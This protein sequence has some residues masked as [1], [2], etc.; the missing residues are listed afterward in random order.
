MFKEVRSNNHVIKQPTSHIHLWGVYLYF[1]HSISKWPP[2]LSLTLFDNQW[3]EMLD[4]SLKQNPKCATSVDKKQNWI[5]F[6]RLSVIQNQH[7]QLV[8]GHPVL[9]LSLTMTK[10]CFLQNDSIRKQKKLSTAVQ[11]CLF[12]FLWKY[13]V[14]IQSSQIWLT[15]LVYI[16]KKE[17]KSV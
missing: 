9:M 13:Q 14:N 3:S 1:V 17:W 15:Y 8:V 10:I 7:Q 4:F 6:N 16:V 2:E 5:I 11:L 12:Q